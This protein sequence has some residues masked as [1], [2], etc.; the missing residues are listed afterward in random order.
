MVLQ[1]PLSVLM[2]VGG[3]RMQRLESH[4]LAV[5]ASLVALL[6]C[7]PL[8][9]LSLVIGIWSLFVLNRPH[10]KQAFAEV[11]RLKR[12]GAMAASA[13]PNAERNMRRTATLMLTVGMLN[14]AA[15]AILF[16][17]MLML[18]VGLGSNIT[19][20]PAEL[21]LLV[22]SA[23]TG[24]VMIVGGTTMRRLRSDSS[25]WMAAVVALL[26][27]SLLWPINIIVGIW[28]LITLRQA[29]VGSAM[30]RETV[31]RQMPDV[32][33]ETFSPTVAHT[34]PAKP[35][36]AT[37]KPMAGEEFTPAIRSDVEAPALGLIIF[38]VLTLIA[39]GGLFMLGFFEDPAPLDTPILLLLVTVPF[40]LLTIVGGVAMH[41]CRSRALALLGSCAAMLPV[42]PL[43]LLGFPLGLW[44]LLVLRRSRIRLMFH[45]NQ[46]RPFRR[47]L[48]QGH[49]R[50][51]L[52]V[53]ISFLLFTA[54][55]AGLLGIARWVRS[56][57]S[58][59]L[60]IV[61][62]FGELDRMR[63]SLDRGADP[64]ARD[65]DGTPAIVAA[66]AG[67][68]DKAIELLCRYRADVNARD[69]QG[70]TALMKAAYHGHLQAMS[71]LQQSGA[72][73][74]AIDNE[75]R[76]ALYWALV[77]GNDACVAQL[78][79]FGSDF[80]AHRKDEFGRSMLAV[81]AAHCPASVPRFIAIADSVDDRDND[82]RTPLMHAAAAGNTQAINVLLVNVANINAHDMRG[83]TPLDWAVY[84]DQESAVKLLLEKGAE[85]TGVTHLWEGYRLAIDARFSE[86][87]APLETAREKLPH[88]TRVGFQVKNE[89]FLA[90]LPQLFALAALAECQLRSGNV[91]AARE[92]YEQLGE[93]VRHQPLWI[94]TRYDLS[95]E[96]M[97][98]GDY[99]PD[100]YR[101]LDFTLTF[102]ALQKALGE[103][104]APPI[105]VVRL[106]Q[107]TTTGDGHVGSR[108]ENTSSGTARG[109]FAK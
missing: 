12:T 29:D 52:L 101:K 40:S 43:V 41:Q 99:D 18:S 64:N 26:P 47:D 95:P 107:V 54:L 102:D 42:G 31:A 24:G 86:A 97:R 84:R 34:Q 89:L 71:V 66:A 79:R 48:E 19:L 90:E 53:G 82:H 13:E 72:E 75:G 2:I 7:Q 98:T 106:E 68:H 9:P 25:A 6:P 104:L 46:E 4:G 3:W 61:S 21:I 100:N 44:A 108:S 5:L 94:Y 70:Q 65:A 57:A 27:V 11:V 17:L 28:A 14:C 33:R 77:G 63:S 49:R 81:A 109:L 69:A 56:A 62:A 73:A 16:L 20:G 92:H 45:E 59:D 50:T 30:D 23:A 37:G 80:G 1:W 39:H 91:E 76:P 22:T 35:M 78:F 88:N 55:I 51:W 93:Q 36:A 32:P 85:K 67:G 58:H 15:P 74:H 83:R 60:A 87:I 10:I 38:G 103:P 8:F 96:R 105:F